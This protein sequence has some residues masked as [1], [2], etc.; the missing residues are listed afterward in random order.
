MCSKS[1]NEDKDNIDQDIDV[2]A[3]G[4]QTIMESDHGTLRNQNKLKILRL[5]LIPSVQDS[6]QIA[7]EILKFDRK[8]ENSLSRKYSDVLTIALW[9]KW[10]LSKL[11]VNK[12][13]VAAWRYASRHS[14]LFRTRFEFIGIN[15]S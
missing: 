1:R 5:I 15:W 7:V 4:V 10:Q 8:K 6:S 12:R 3:M 13:Y 14:S 11:F 2:C 9:S